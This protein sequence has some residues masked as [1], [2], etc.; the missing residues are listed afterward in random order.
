MTV[1]SEGSLQFT[2][3]ASCHA[4]KY[5]DWSFFRNQFQN[6]CGGAKAVDI[7]CISADTLWLIEIKDYRQHKRTKPQ[8]I[9][10]EIAIKVRDTLAGLVAAK[11]NANDVNEKRFAKNALQSKMI[12]VVLHLE[13][14]E[15]QSRL[16]PQA[17][18]PAAALQSLKRQLK[19]ID[20]HPRVVD[21][22][23]LPNCMDWT[24]AGCEV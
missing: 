6:T 3:G 21:K 16:F 24:V 17:I 14:P 20:A 10:D 12:K 18:D 11:M 23:S 19:A 15:K 8:D 22:N 5:D 1:L 2:F 9:G 13:Q 7:A 4:E